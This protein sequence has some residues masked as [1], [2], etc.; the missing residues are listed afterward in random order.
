MGRNIKCKALLWRV[1]AGDPTVST[2]ESNPLPK[3]LVRPFTVPYA[4]LRERD[5]YQISLRE[6]TVKLG[7]KTPPMTI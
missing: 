3:R 4:M 5:L 7:Q 2:T 1:G 6:G